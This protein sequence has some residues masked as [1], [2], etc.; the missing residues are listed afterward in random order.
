MSEKTI[1]MLWRVTVLI[2]VFWMARH[3]YF[4]HHD[5]IKADT[6]RAEDRA[7]AARAALDQRI[8]DYMNCKGP[9]CDGLYPEAALVVKKA[10]AAAA[11]QSSN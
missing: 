3:E 8:K 2:I 5:S 7:T 10:E 9:A 11:K 4:H 1:T 6:Q